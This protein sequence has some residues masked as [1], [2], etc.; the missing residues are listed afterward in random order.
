MDERR[1]ADGEQRAADKDERE[2]GE[3][4][5]AACHSPLACDLMHRCCPLGFGND[6]PESNPGP[7]CFST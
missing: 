3:T 4:G 2:H 5:E 6:G 1:S 7:S